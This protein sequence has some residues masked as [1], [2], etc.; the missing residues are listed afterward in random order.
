MLLQRL[1]V[2]WAVLGWELGG[3][4]LRAN[5]ANSEHDVETSDKTRIA[6]NDIKF[7]VSNAFVHVAMPQQMLSLQQVI[8]SMFSVA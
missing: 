5:S 6:L 7:T 8:N 2:S 1:L 4:L 3:H